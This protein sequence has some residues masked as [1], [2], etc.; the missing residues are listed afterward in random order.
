M[1]RAEL[2]R[3]DREDS[4]HLVL[5]ALGLARAFFASDPSSLPGSYDSL[6]GSGDPDRVVIEDVIAMN[7]TM[8][9]MSGRRAWEP[10][11]SGDQSWLAAIPRDLDLIETEESEWREIGGDALL[12]AAIQ[13]CIHRG[14]G[15]AGVTKLL[16]LKRPRLIPILDSFVAQMMGVAIPE[17]PDLVEFSL[18]FSSAFEVQHWWR[19]AAEEGPNLANIGA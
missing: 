11:L 8:R 16:H 3:I 12:S 9:A 1:I 14:I 2:L 4:E 19:V 6:A 17:E 15:L 7:T 10:V 18:A 13:S 5:D